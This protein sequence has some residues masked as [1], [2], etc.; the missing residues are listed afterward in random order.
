MYIHNGQHVATRNHKNYDQPGF[1]VSS[2]RVSIRY[3]ALYI[4]KDRRQC[5]YQRLVAVSFSATGG[6]APVGNPNA[7]PIGNPVST[8]N[9]CSNSLDPGY[10]GRREG[11][12]QVGHPP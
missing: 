3:I 12:G 1:S 4:R 6:Q 8:E 9:D 5:H 11:G 2:V 7:N 10:Q